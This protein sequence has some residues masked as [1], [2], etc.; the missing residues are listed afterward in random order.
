MRGVFPEETQK[1][2]QALKRK[3]DP[4]NMF[5]VG[6]WQYEANK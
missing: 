3:H 1:R 5:K 2:L 6:V 4:K